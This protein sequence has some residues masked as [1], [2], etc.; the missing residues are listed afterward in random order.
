MKKRK[1]Q[2]RPQCPQIMENKTPAM[3][4]TGGRLAVSSHPEKDFFRI[5]RKKLDTATGMDK[6]PDMRATEALSHSNSAVLDSPAR[7]THIIKTTKPHRV[8][9]IEKIQAMYADRDALLIEKLYDYAVERGIY[10]IES[11]IH[12][13]F[14]AH[15]E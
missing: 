10:D 12:D 14:Y 5:I 7:Y 3:V 6:M 4:L 8:P 15:L 11:Y 9:A 2:K 13:S 1:S